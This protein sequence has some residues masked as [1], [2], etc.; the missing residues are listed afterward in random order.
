M[1]EL[2]KIVNESLPYHVVEK[3]I[4]CLDRDGNEVKPELPNG[5][6]FEQ[7]VLDMIHL[8]KSC[9]PFEVERERE[10]APVKNRTGVDSVETAR[11][12]LEKNGKVL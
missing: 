10:F 4:P 7:L 11:T 2:E 8:A 9:L 3:K 5:Y 12:L 1:D 6:K